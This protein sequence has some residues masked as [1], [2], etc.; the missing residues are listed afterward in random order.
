M[1]VLLATWEAEA[2]GLLEKEF[3]IS[4]GNNLVPQ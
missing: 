1:F 4:I 3:E 2:E